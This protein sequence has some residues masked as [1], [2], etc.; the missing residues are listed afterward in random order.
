MKK[1]IYAI[2][3]SLFIIYGCAQQEIPIPAEPVPTPQLQEVPV[4]EPIVEEEPKV[5][6]IEKTPE[7]HCQEQAIKMVPETFKFT[8]V[9]EKDPDTAGWSYVEDTKWTD[10][11]PMDTKGDIEFQ[12]GRHTDEDTK[13]FYTRNIQNEDLFGEGGLK[14]LKKVTLEDG[15]VGERKFYIKPSFEPVQII[16][17]DEPFAPHRGTFKVVD[18]GFVSC[19]WS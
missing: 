10:D 9:A 6:E 13:I 8:L 3:I 16:D 19:D 5:E 15:T 12:R 18:Y 4:E 14:Y 2:I 1:I 11:T 7:E 17:P